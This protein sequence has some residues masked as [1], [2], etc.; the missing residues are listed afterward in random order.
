MKTVGVLPNEFE[1]WCGK[2]IDKKIYDLSMSSRAEQT[3]TY[4]P[5]MVFYGNESLVISA[6]LQKFIEDKRSTLKYRMDSMIK[7]AL[8]D[9]KIR[10]SRIEFEGDSIESNNIQS[11]LLQEIKEKLYGKEV[12]AKGSIIFV[13]GELWFFPN[14][15]QFS[16]TKQP[17]DDIS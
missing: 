14:Q 13:H 11:V 16:Y 1:F 10:E 7:E 12:K 3:F 6:G 9:L 8:K 4:P 5:S 15:L 2:Q 17:Q